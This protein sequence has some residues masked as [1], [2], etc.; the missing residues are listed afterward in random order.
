[1]TRLTNWDKEIIGVISKRGTGDAKSGRARAKGYKE[2]RASGMSQEEAL[3]DMTGGTSDIRWIYW[4]PSA[5][6]HVRF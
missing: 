2:R 6:R 1:M 5:K 3:D 4:L